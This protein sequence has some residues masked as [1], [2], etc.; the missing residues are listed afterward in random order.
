MSESINVGKHELKKI[1][2]ENCCSDNTNTDKM[3]TYIML[4]VDTH[5]NLVELPSV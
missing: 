1:D 2:V 4:F 3:K 5:M